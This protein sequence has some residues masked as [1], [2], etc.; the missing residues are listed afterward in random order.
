MFA[1]FVFALMA[2][3]VLAAGAQAQQRSQPVRSATTRTFVPVRQPEFVPPIYHRPYYP[4]VYR[5]PVFYPPIFY[6]PVYRPPYFPYYPTFPRYG[7]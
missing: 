5:P 3:T 7:W 1:R 6:P 4:P 2:V